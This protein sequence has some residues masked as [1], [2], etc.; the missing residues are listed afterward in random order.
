MLKENLAIYLFIGFLL[1]LFLNYIMR[2]IYVFFERYDLPNEIKTHSKPVPHSGGVAVFLSF[3]ITLIILRFTTHFPTGTLRELRYII[4][5][6]FFIFMIGIIDD[7]KKPKGLGPYTKFFIETIVAFFI[8]FEGFKIRFIYPEYVAWFLS[9]LWIVGITN[10]INIIDIMDGLAGS[11]ILIASIS[12]FFITLPQEEL[13]VNIVSGILA[14]SILGFLPYNLSLSKKVFLGD[15]G[16]LFCGFLLSVMSLGA[17][18]SDMNPL[19]V[20]APIFILS[21]PIFDT[22]YVSYM[23]IKKGLSPFKGSKDHY[24]LRLHAIGFSKKDVVLISAIFCVL[25]SILSYILTKVNIQVGFIL[26]ALLIFVFY[27]VGR[28]LSKV[29]I[30]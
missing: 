2:R 5:S 16:S 11:Q 18:Y 20:Y 10:A 15:S 6:S 26:F 19:G 14:V 8:V 29:D 3:I 24:A 21:V 4:I 22:F 1:S 30:V 12:F 17:R 7:I 27:L 23:R 25:A 28:Y 13:Y 9:V